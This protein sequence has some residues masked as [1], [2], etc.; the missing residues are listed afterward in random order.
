MDKGIFM[1][2]KNDNKSEHFYTPKETPERFKEK[3]KDVIQVEF[4]D[5]EGKRVV[6]TYE[7]KVNK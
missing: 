3:D 4:V 5:F 7:K 2:V 6:R 1:A